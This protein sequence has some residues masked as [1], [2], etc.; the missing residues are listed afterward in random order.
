ME[1]NKDI[2]II[3]TLVYK[4]RA[5]SRT[6]VIGII[7]VVDLGV[8]S[9]HGHW[10]IFRHLPGSLDQ[11]AASSLNGLGVVILLWLLRVQRVVSLVASC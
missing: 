11:R 7:S 9:D 6:L 2:H 4:V 5:S 8:Q 1:L 3:V 10:F